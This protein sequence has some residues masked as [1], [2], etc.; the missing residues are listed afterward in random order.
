MARIT[1]RLAARN[2]GF[3]TQ[4][5]RTCFDADSAL[6]ERRSNTRLAGEGTA[7][8]ARSPRIVGLCRAATTAAI[9]LL[10]SPSSLAITAATTAVSSSTPT[11]ARIGCSPANSAARLAAPAGSRKSSVSSPSGFSA[12][13]ALASSEATVTSTPTLSAASRKS[14]V[15]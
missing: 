12:S 5:N 1:P 10:G 11:T 15:R 8:S 4:G 14:G 13:T 6:S 9:G 7:A 2:V 3:T